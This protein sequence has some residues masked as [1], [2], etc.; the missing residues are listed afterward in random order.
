MDSTLAEAVPHRQEK[1]DQDFH[2]PGS[3][4]H[5]IFVL[6]RTAMDHD[7]AVRK[8]VLYLLRGG[9][10]H[11]HFDEVVSEFP[12]KLRTKRL[13]ELPY[14]AWELLEHLRI[15]QW[16]IVEFSR[17]SEHRSPDFPEGYW[18]PGDSTPDEVAWNNSIQVFR[19]ELLAMQDLISDPKNDI[20]AP[21]P[22]GSGQTLLR[23]AL[24]LADHNAYHIGQMVI[25]RRLLGCW[26]R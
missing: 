15:A 13:P 25:L 22:H 14:T 23:E 3:E 26:S 19:A 7:S 20:L 9:G 4:K 16:D 10:A 17:N 24:L 8:H 21:I 12:I 1:S 2:V 5:A 18:P 6:R 11:V